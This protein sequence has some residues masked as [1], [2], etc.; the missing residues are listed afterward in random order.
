MEITHEITVDV[1]T[2]DEDAM[3]EVMAEIENACNHARSEVRA[4]TISQS[5]TSVTIEVSGDA[6]DMSYFLRDYQGEI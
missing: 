1:D 5:P 4:V 2:T 6:E 3:Y